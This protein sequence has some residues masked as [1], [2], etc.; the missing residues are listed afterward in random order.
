VTSS[1]R[2]CN[3]FLRRA[4]QE[5][6]RPVAGR[7]LLFVLGSPA[8]D[9]DSVI[10]S[11]AYG[12]LLHT[13]SAE[14]R[15]VVPFLPI[16]RRDLQLRPELLLLLRRVELDS[17][18]LLCSDQ[19]NLEKRCRQGQARLVL[20]DTPGQDLDG[21][22]AACV[23]EVVDH[24]L[25]DRRAASLRGARR[26]IR[27][28]VGSTCTLVAEQLLARAPQ[29]LDAGLAT[30]LLGAIL[31]DTAG[32]D[33]AAGRTTRKDSE[34]AARLV[35]ASGADSGELYAQ[36]QARRR[37]VGRV[38]SGDLLRRDFKAAQAGPIR[39]GLASVPR[40]SAQWK[41]RPESLP[42]ALHA[43]R[44]ARGLDVLL[45]LMY[46]D[47]DNREFRRELAVCTGEAALQRELLRFL[48]SLPLGLKA[49]PSGG[50]TASRSRGQAR[51]P[52]EGT[53]PR[54]RRAPGAEATGNPPPA[55]FFEQS[56]V[57]FSRKRLDPLLRCF[58]EGHAARR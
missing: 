17:A 6:F 40:L 56:A 7:E 52:A 53:S 23:V 19:F 24:H 18:N 49:R 14:G 12:Y 35:A 33:A 4:M 28:T 9:L 51:S 5:V 3:L 55:A 38:S 8:A 43:F 22:L 39:Y 16:A 46:S 2:N 32:L 10:A 45:V 47:G 54:K 25:A 11:V 27:E 48:E 42:R 29:L 41:E 44:V 34:M 57:E 50:T 37:S 30:L 1:I 31:V 58:L 26:V 36:L 13:E 15:A 21:E 20:V